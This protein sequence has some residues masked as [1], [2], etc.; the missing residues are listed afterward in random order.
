MKIAEWLVIQMVHHAPL[1]GERVGMMLRRRRRNEARREGGEETRGRRI[2][3]R[4]RGSSCEM[5][6]CHDL[7]LPPPLISYIPPPP[8][9]ELALC[10]ATRKAVAD[11]CLTERPLTLEFSGLASFGKRVVFASLVEGESSERLRAIA[12]ETSYSVLIAISLVPFFQ[13]QIFVLFFHNPITYY[14][15]F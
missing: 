13:L 15:I 4:G 7:S 5:E 3:M 2:G 12:G 6:W 14:C 8:R 11:L 1:E 9:A 10:D